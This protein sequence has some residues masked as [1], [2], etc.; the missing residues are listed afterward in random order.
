MSDLWDS[1]IQFRK[2]I[3][4]ELF[5]HFYNIYTSF[6][7]FKYYFQA[8]SEYVILLLCLIKLVPKEI[9]PLWCIIDVCE[10]RAKGTQCSIK[11]TYS[12]DEW[13]LASCITTLM[14]TRSKSA[15]SFTI[16]SRERLNWMLENEFAFARNVKNERE[17]FP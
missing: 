1:S 17:P 15:I 11:N 14:T 4:L 10:F 8:H 5:V 16:V 6:S 3:C 9:N 13:G 2:A 7:I 12:A